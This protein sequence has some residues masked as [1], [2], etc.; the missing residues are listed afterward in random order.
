METRKII[1]GYVA[2][3]EVTEGNMDEIVQ[4]VAG[5]IPAF[6][7]KSIYI[8]IRENTDLVI[9]SPSLGDNIAYNIYRAIFGEPEK[10]L[11]DQEVNKGRCIDLAEA[12]MEFVANAEV[13][14]FCSGQGFILMDTDTAHHTCG[15]CSGVGRYIKYD[16]IETPELEPKLKEDDLPF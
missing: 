8:A 12:I 6:I 16:D 1:A 15:A 7:G 2:Q 5:M 14:G 3:D 11:L 10:D 9:H 4:D 13:C